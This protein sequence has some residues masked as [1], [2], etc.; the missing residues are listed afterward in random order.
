MLAP[1]FISDFSRHWI[2]MY[3]KLSF[4]RPKI[5]GVTRIQTMVLE[6]LGVPSVL[7]NSD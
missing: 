7:L 5:H 3:D 1:L 4:L 6:M 2:W